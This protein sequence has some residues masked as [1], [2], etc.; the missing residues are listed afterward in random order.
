MYSRTH[1]I[2]HWPTFLLPPFNRAIANERTN[3]ENRNGMY[4]QGTSKTNTSPPKAQTKD[5]SIEVTNKNKTPPPIV[6]RTLKHHHQRGEKSKKKK[7]STS[8]KD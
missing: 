3:E 6:Q 1:G 4:T 8:I 5:T 2:Q 7:K